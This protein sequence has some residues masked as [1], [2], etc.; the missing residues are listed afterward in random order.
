MPL[1]PL[2][3]C[4]F[5]SPLLDPSLPPSL[6]PLLS[7]N[8]HNLLDTILEAHGLAT[9]R[10]VLL[11]P[12]SPA[13]QL[14]PTCC[15]HNPVLSDSIHRG[16]LAWGGFKTDPELFGEENQS[17]QAWSCRNPCPWGLT[18]PPLQRPER[19]HHPARGTQGCGEHP[20]LQADPSVLDLDCRGLSH[21]LHTH[22]SFVLASEVRSGWQT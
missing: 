10:H 15:L 16:M 18:E 7:V 14:V 2:V 17:R 11:R 8:S 4:H 6:L 20:T 3:C 13:F 19:Q 21:A 22:S 5:C 1:V 9:T 12:E